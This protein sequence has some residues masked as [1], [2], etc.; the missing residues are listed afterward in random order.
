MACTYIFDVSQV[1]LGYTPR[2][3]HVHFSKMLYMLLNSFHNFFPVSNVGFVCYLWL[4]VALF[5]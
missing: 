2:L 4:L 3:K 1:L 5:R